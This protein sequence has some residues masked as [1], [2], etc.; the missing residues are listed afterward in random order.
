MV[1]DRDRDKTIVGYCEPLSLRAGEPI[2]LHAS[3]HVPGPVGLDIVRIV[4][5]DPTRSGPGF[6]ERPVVTVAAHRGGPR[7]AAA[8]DRARGVSSSSVTSRQPVGP[9]C[10]CTCWRRD[11]SS[12]RPPGRCSTGGA[13]RWSPSA[14]P[15]GSSSSP[16]TA[17]SRPVRRAPIEPGRWYRVEVALDIAPTPRRRRSASWGWRADRRGATSSSPMDRR[18]RPSALAWDGSIGQLL[19]GRGR[20]GRALRRAPRRAVAR[21][22]R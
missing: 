1:E 4:C 14:S 18:T 9:S 15:M 10:A 16:S 19:L 21:R 22:R 13:T 5:G 2:A 8:A 11:R 17:S 12:A 6:E 3:S 7:R 20:S